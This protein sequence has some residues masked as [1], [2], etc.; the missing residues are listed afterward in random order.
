MYIYVYVC[1]CVKLL[2]SFTCMI[3][4]YILDD[5]KINVYIQMST[6]WEKP[7]WIF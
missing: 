3:Y 7:F 1:V 4:K 6:E 5:K 2:F